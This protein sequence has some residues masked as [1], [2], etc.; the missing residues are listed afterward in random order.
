MRDD[1]AAGQVAAGGA[2]L[3]PAWR[4]WLFSV[5]TFGAAALA[6]AIAMAAGLDRPYWAMA[7][8]YIASQPLSGATRSKALYRL[9]G[10]LLGAA[11][12][13]VLVPN[14]AD[15]P[16]LL[17][18]AVAL[19]VG[20]CLTLALVDRTP[21]SYVFMLAAYS[22]PI[23]G[24][25]CVDSPQA[26]WDVAVARTEEIGL[27]I[28]CAAVV[29]G[30]VFPRHVGPVLGARI[31]D[32]L[33][34]ATGWTLDVLEGRE[35]PDSARVS[36]RRLAADAAEI[37]ALAAHLAFDPSMQQLAARSVGPLRARMLMLLP[38]IASLSDR[39]TALRQAGGLSPEVELVLERVAARLRGRADDDPSLLSAIT[40]LAPRMADTWRGMLLVSLAM[41]LTELLDLRADCRALHAGIEAGSQGQAPLR[42]Q[43]RMQP[44]AARHRDWTMA[45][46]SGLAAGMTVALVCA[47]WILIAW[48]EGA[49]AAEMAAVA[50]CFFATMDNPVPAIVDFLRWTVVAILVDALYLFAV[51]PLVR[52]FVPLMLALAPAYL[53]FGVLAARPR[54]A[55]IGMA[56][57]ANG[58]TLLGL[59]GSYSGD[60]TGFV[61]AAVAAALGM[62]VAGLLTALIRSVG[63]EWSV[64]R[65]LQANWRDLAQAAER[66]GMGDRMAFA[67]L[68][69][70]RFAA[71]VPRLRALAPDARLNGADALAELRMGLNIVDLRRA[72]HGLPPSADAAIDRVLDDVA[73]YCR[74]RAGDP[75]KLLQ[76]P[77]LRL[78]TTVNAA[79]AAVGAAGAS[80]G[81]DDALQGLVGIRRVL[82][83][84]A[85]PYEPDPA[86][87]L[88][89]DAE[90]A[91]RQAA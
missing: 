81:R 36:R 76:A 15:A 8:V 39:L 65:L 43:P 46:L 58:A 14:L 45:L 32:W 38:V 24:L 34:D 91:M 59:Q 17:T 62:A 26:V 19:W 41:R 50:C 61:N 18:A 20:M 72:R 85:A 35:T 77:P 12:A 57:A 47:G 67:A 2:L 4:D 75:G 56:L 5:R 3:M 52:D 69:L 21:R 68:M 23:I 55:P 42:F 84:T 87:D 60:F 29:A 80:S 70:D 7:S 31:A 79:L 90:L 82:F 10:T 63:A 54:L 53:L 48:P 16:A 13:V 66:R 6:L 25:P 71:V 28:V 1:S 51:L 22:V 88:V 89:G 40:A 78:L 83:P 74:G 44:P 49:V 11:G 33:R 9:C 73:Q 27:G 30:V 86:P 37:D 64:W